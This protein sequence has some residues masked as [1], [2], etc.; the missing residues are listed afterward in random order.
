MAGLV[1][2]NTQK[3]VEAPPAADHERNKAIV[4]QYLNAY[5]VGDSKGMAA[6]LTDDY[7]G[8]G[9]GVSSVSDKA[10]T[11][12]SVDVHWEKYKYGGKRFSLI[13]KIAMTTTTDGGRG[14]P[15]GDWVMIWGDMETDYPATPDY[16]DKAV[17]AKFTFHATY[18]VNKE[19][20]IDMSNTYFNHEDVMKQLGY[21]YL[22]VADQKKVEKLKLDFK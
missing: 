2:C 17:T 14:R 16:G 6:L 15:A 21:R 3:P 18:R 11:L 4:D 22:S 20:K 9:L 12:E 8:F 19:G 10:K 7:Q 5:L 1:A 13:E